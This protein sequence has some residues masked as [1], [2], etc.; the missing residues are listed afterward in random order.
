[1]STRRIVRE[2]SRKETHSRNQQY[3]LAAGIFLCATCV[4]KKKQ[5]AA[6]RARKTVTSVV[7]VPRHVAV[8]IRAANIRGR[9]AAGD[10]GWRSRPAGADGRRAAPAHASRRRRGIVQTKSPAPIALRDGKNPNVS[11][12]RHNSGI[13]VGDATEGG[14]TAEPSYFNEPKAL[15]AQ[16][17][18]PGEFPI[19]SIRVAQAQWETR[20]RMQGSSYRR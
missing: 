18:H 8:D 12:K 11:G 6:L 4:L 15:P 17:A 5:P 14:A 7:R 3:R 9:A 19:F 10:A 1:M 16:P 13:S 2:T 20:A